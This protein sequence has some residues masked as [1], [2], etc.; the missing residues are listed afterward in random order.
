MK[1]L[2]LSL[3]NFFSKHRIA[4][5]LILIITF[6]SLS[7][8]ATRIKFEEDISKMLG[9]SDA[10]QKYNSIIQNTK[11]ADKLIVNIT[12]KDTVSGSK[13]D[14][15]SFA[16]SI[17]PKLQN[18]D[19][20]LIK[21]VTYKPEDLPF[22]QVYEIILKNLP[23]FLANSD[24]SSFD[25]LL[26]PQRVDKYLGNCLE[27]LASPN[28]IFIKKTL[29]YDPLGF[30]LPSLNRLKQLGEATNYDLSDG[31][32]ISK[33]QNSLVIIIEPAN[34]INET[35]KNTIL[36]NK[37]E[38]TISSL[39][40]RN[41]FQTINCSYFGS[42]A[43]A[44][45]NAKQIQK[46]TYLT[47]AVLIISILVLSLVFFRKKRTIILIFLPIIFGLVFAMALV[48]IIKPSIS[49]IAIGA[50][51]VLLGIAVNYPL[52]LL[53]HYLHEKDLRNVIGNMV[54][55]MT[56]GSATTI[57]GFLCL[58]F[59]KSEILNDFGLLGAFSLLGAAI[60]SLIFLPH[61]IGNIKSKSSKNYL[62]KVL[63]RVSGYQID[64]KKWV[65]IAIAAITP[66]L[67]YY[68]GKVDFDSDLYHLNYMSPKLIS[69]EKELNGSNS[70]YTPL[71]IVNYGNSIDEVLT[72]A[73]QLLALSDSL[74]NLG[75][76]SSYTSI[77]NIIPSNIE[78]A[79]RIDQWKNYW[80]PERRNETLK[81]LEDASR[82]YGFK[83][84][85]FN[86]F[87]SLIENPATSI[88]S[89]DYQ[90]LIETFGN[91]VLSHKSDLIT[92]VSVLKIPTQELDSIEGR[93]KS[94]SNTTIFDKKFLANQLIDSVNSDFNFITYFTAILVFIAL[95]I[96]Y[97]RI[98]LAL[99]TFIPMALSWVWILGFMGL[100]GLKFNVVNI[101]LSTFIF[102][103]GD[104]Y[105]IF[106]M[107]SLMQEY[108]TGKK[109]LQV[110]RT[111]IIISG[112][113]T[114]IGFG[115]LLLAEHPAIRSI[116][117]ISMIGIISVLFL[118]QTI[119]P[120][121]FKLFVR[122]PS[123][124]RRVPISLFT[125]I[126]SI[127]AFTFFVTGSILLTVIGFLLII[128]NPFAK[129][130]ARKFFNLLI[131]KFAWAQIYIML[132]VKK[133]VIYKEKID[134]S[135]PFVLI[136]NHQSVV[137]ILLIIML[138]P[139]I[140]LL[141]NKWVWNSPIFGYVVRMAGY[142]PI[143]EGVDVN[144]D[145]IKR[146]V[147]EGYSI[148]V[149]PEGTRSYDGK[150]N[151][152][153]KGAFFLADSLKLD[154]VP[155]LLHGVNRCIPKGTFIL[156]DD[157]I[158]IK[159]LP[160]I[161]YYDKNFGITY[162]EKTKKI[163]TYFKTEY[164]S[165][166]TEIEN[167]N[168]FINELKSNFIYKGPVLEWYL[169]IKLRL[170]KNYIQF[171]KLV[172]K[173]GLIIDA[174]CGY[175]F[176]SYILGYTSQ[177]RQ[178]IGID[179]DDEK[180]IVAQNGYTKPINARFESANLLNYSW[181]SADCIIMSDVMHYLSKENR[182][183]AF[184]NAVQAL[185]IG[186]TIIVRDGDVS[187]VKKHRGTKLTEFFSTK[188]LSFNKTENQLEFFSSDSLISLAKSLGLSAQ[189]IDNTKLSS[190]VI[191]VFKKN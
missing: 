94:L 186:G 44:V 1:T 191:I 38:S 171:D 129:V 53:T 51:S 69:A 119:E 71:Y 156:H 143:I 95:L 181:P 8:L 105:C 12:L 108:K 78:Q 93:I 151:R 85:A 10:M 179:Y 42:T 188:V 100:L 183:I 177:E 90:L 139:K 14:L 144:I 178:I 50:S 63:D 175:G 145:D 158:S 99:V 161:S 30:S 160:R 98:E 3:F 27:S 45:S 170:E 173:S 57:G 48:S 112:I 60:F 29:V 190:N 20:K 102:G 58:L 74:N 11:L 59:V 22:F 109:Q 7:L 182:E 47:V 13:S 164:N 86:N 115:V 148:A 132:N 185:N 26:T 189:I 104:D 87:K 153:H 17:V 52:H 133:T 25:S 88:D 81:S 41:E 96:T 101:I 103:L 15:I 31:Y 73:H 146:R 66:V 169:K 5:W 16:D 113:T 131:S 126:K 2:I 163:S 154:I 49:L 28:G 187:M 39:L 24:Y 84:H 19:S 75:I 70:K 111:S 174:G 184:F 155:V 79:K 80:T 176:M 168:Y 130:K 157:Q 40:S 62:E 123:T 56:I 106:I 135:K 64:T 34:S 167:P 67:F 68:C 72:S 83:A 152:F 97:G 162:Q 117:A 127:F 172:P 18:I 6:L 61:L 110:V 46:D 136:S 77:S 23:F 82:K 134:F 32:F 4:F 116:A 43:I 149:F 159:V 122:K 89:S 120:F 33:K 21:K 35:G 76:K 165:F 180:I 166:K 150:L 37:I 36:I 124:L 114:L 54:V 137:D 121:L 138:N 140:V 118:S 125:L 107:D 92:L 128:I 142:C 141:T 65:L 91:D 9:M 147:A 55:P